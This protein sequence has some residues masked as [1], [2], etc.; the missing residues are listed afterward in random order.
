MK[1]KTFRVCWIKS[2]KPCL[3]ISQNSKVLTQFNFLL[4]YERTVSRVQTSTAKAIYSH[5]LLSLR[6]PLSLYVR[7]FLCLVPCPHK[8][9]ML[10]L[11]P[12]SFTSYFIFFIYF[13]IWIYKL[14]T[15]THNV[16]SY[17]CYALCSFGWHKVNI[18]KVCQTNTIQKDGTRIYDNSVHRCYNQGND[19]LTKLLQGT[20]LLFPSSLEYLC[21]I[22]EKRIFLNNFKIC[23]DIFCK[24]FRRVMTLTQ[25]Q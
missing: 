24:E 25:K 17:I 14:F 3:N 15:W 11:L 23:W 8:V 2:I 22:D 16:C 18:W 9:H 4:L 20:F 1:C 10:K 7:I 13:S 21:L 5:K 12:I 19:F 6:F